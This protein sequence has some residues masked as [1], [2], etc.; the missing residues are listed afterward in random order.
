MTAACKQQ[1]A[2]GDLAINTNAGDLLPV[3]IS[4]ILIYTSTFIQ[5]SI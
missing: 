3:P 5:I 1:Q 2:A 4:S